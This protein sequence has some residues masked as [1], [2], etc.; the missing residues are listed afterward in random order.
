MMISQ[1]TSE[2]SGFWDY[3]LLMFYDEF[4]HTFMVTGFTAL[5][6]FG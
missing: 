6:H 3:G 1:A 2:D 4:A 5:S